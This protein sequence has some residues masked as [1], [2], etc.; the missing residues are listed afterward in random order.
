MYKKAIIKNGGEDFS[1]HPEFTCKQLQ[2]M[3]CNRDYPADSKLCE[4]LKR[5]K[6]VMKIK[7][8]QEVTFPET[9]KS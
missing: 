7:Y 3:N 8:T 2:S 5:E 9:Q 4:A 6:E 1:D